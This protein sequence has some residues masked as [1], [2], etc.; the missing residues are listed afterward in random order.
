MD[1]DQYDTPIHAGS[2]PSRFLFFPGLPFMNSPLED[3][4][5]KMPG[6]IIRPEKLSADDADRSA[7][8]FSFLLPF[9]SSPSHNLSF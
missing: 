9:H 5:S 3:L 6:D 4:P 1:Y 2:S 8:P 7:F